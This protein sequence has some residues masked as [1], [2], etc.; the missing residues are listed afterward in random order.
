MRLV[1]G[2]PLAALSPDHP[3]PPAAL[4]ALRHLYGLD[5][6]LL[7]QLGHFFGGLLR[8]DLG[9]SLQY[10]RPV[11]ELIAER[12]PATLLLGG[13]ALILNF[14]LGLWLGVRQAV[15][16]GGLLDRALSGLALAG[17]T[18]PVFWL[19]LLFVWIGALHW[20]LF[21]VAGMS[22]PLLATG[23]GV[24]RHGLDL[25]HHLALPAL[26][27]TVATIAVTMR[28][29]RSAM[30]T[31]LEAE[32]IVTA[33]AKGLPE[34]TVIRRHAWRTA[35]GPI[36]TLLGLSVPAL[37]AGAVLTEA[38]FA[39]PGLGTLAAG[40]VSARDYPVAMGCGALVASLVVLG[41]LG[42]DVLHTVLDPRV[43]R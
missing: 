22:D 6:P 11:G 20:H 18:L 15:A 31:A 26:T 27:L 10:G 42:A 41:N 19:G 37:V 36:V 1:P 28:H 25:A 43:R 30:L 5:Q 7:V 40:A 21:P 35:L 2:D 4:D 14:T 34:S 12:L 38:V 8:G 9:L 16:R 13:T 23:A 3:L 29:Q 24:W 32:W 39:W 33:R 17:Y